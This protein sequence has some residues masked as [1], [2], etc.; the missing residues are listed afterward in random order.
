MRKR[1]LLAIGKL[2]RSQEIIDSLLSVVNAACLQSQTALLDHALEKQS[3]IVI[4][5]YQENK[6]RPFHFFLLPEFLHYC[7]LALAVPKWANRC[8]S[9]TEGDRP[10]HAART[11]GELQRHERRKTG[12]AGF[13]FGD[14]ANQERTLRFSNA[15]PAGFAFP[16]SIA[17]RHLT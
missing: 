11:R 16:G 5:L 15:H 6:R 17:V 2:P 13:V 7:L 14:S 12:G 9:H 4:V 8:K 10:L 3:I 1:E